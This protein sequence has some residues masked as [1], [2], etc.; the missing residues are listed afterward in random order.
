MRYLSVCAKT[1]SGEE[2]HFEQNAPP[3]D[4]LPSDG[5]RN[6][7]TRLSQLPKRLDTPTDGARFSLSDPM[8]EGRAEGEFAPKFQV[9]LHES[10][11]GKM[12]S[13]K[14]SATVPVALF[15][16]SPNSWCG[17]FHSPFGASGRLQ[18]TRRREAD[19][20]GRDDRAPHL[21]LHRS[22][23]KQGRRNPGNA[24]RL[25]PRHVCARYVAGP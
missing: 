22:G 14:G 13:E 15:G 16:V 5:R 7:Q 20:R 4:P 23:L 1:S 21:Q 18:P 2:A 24:F 25:L 6:S 19:E 10:L 8:G 17:R 3:P 9:V 12:Q 11:A